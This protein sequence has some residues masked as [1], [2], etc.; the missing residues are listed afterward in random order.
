MDCEYGP[1]TS[2]AAHCHQPPEVGACKPQEQTSGKHSVFEFEISS[3]RETM[4]G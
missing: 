1:S 2:Q 4:T 3:V